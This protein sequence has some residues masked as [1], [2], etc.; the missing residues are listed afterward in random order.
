MAPTDRKRVCMLH[1]GGTIGMAPTD[2]GF[3]TRRGH[4]GEEL[5]RMEVLQR[6][7]LPLVDLVE[8]EELLDSADM[9]P[10][11]WQRIANDVAERIA[12]YD[13]FVILHGTDT[14]AY[15]A[16]ALS[17]MLENLDRPVVLTGSQIPLCEIRS[18]A[19][20]NLVDAV[21]VAGMAEIPEVMIQFG[22]KLLRGNR[23]VKVSAEG[24]QAFDSPNFPPLGHTGVRIRLNRRRARP[25]PEGPLR[26]RAMGTAPVASLRLFPGID[27]RVLSPFLE[28]PLEGLVLEAY[29]VGNGPSRNRDII[30]AIGDATAAGLVVVVVSQCFEAN[31]HLTEYATGVAL[32]DAGCVGG[33]DL[34]AEAAMTK[35]LHLFGRGLCVDEV[36]RLMSVD[37]R[38]ELTP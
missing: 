29:G 37:L 1:V 28:S 20:S 5:N 10:A 31:V 15:T 7:E 35:L 21:T 16:S 4:L 14:M 6:P 36:R 12:D 17:F 26:L 2:H 3:G 9:M 33:R 27:A 25:M 38:G 23:S 34:T 19:A 8:Y 13:G 24:F 30:K 11:D 32:A 18:D 22:G